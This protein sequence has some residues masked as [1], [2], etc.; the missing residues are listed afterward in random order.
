MP[1]F[2]LEW[3]LN[4]TVRDSLVKAE[5]AFYIVLLYA[6]Y[7]RTLEFPSLSIHARVFSVLV[8]HGTTVST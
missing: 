2:Y 1:P 6:A 7:A 3:S 5:A 8:L 4:N